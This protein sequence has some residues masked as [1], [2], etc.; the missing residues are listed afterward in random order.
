MFRWKNYCELNRRSIVL[1]PGGK[2]RQRMSAQREVEI[3]LTAPREMTV[4]IYAD[5][6][7]TR[8]S[9][10]SVDTIFYIDGGDNN[11]AQSWFIVVRRD[12]PPELQATLN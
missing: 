11:A 2:S 5:G 8:R 7:L 3:A 10:Q 1:G 12:K 4:S 6:K 9:K